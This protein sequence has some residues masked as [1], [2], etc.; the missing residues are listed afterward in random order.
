ML[1]QVNLRHFGSMCKVKIEHISSP[2]LY[3]AKIKGRYTSDPSL[4]IYYPFLILFKIHTISKKLKNFRPPD[5]SKN[6][7]QK[8]VFSLHTT[9]QNF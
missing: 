6:N 5:S 8:N 3:K 4:R 9:K 7:R 1:F 2:V